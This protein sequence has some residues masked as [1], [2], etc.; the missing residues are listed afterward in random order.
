M[1]A[2][3]LE[4]SRYFEPARFSNFATLLNVVIPLLL[5]VSAFVFL[6]ILMWGGT[7]ML[8]AG[9][10]KE[11]VDTAKKTITYAVAGLATIFLSYLGVKLIAFVFNIQVPL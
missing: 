5:L 3:A 2:H 7:R 9:G 1:P 11:A 4:I 10:N 8:T 6:V